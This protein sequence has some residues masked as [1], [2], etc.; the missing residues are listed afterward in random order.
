MRRKKR[1]GF[2]GKK[3][4]EISREQ[5]KSTEGT[6]ES[7]ASRHVEPEPTPT[8]SG[9]QQERRGNVPT[10]ANVSA[11]K[12]VN[13]SFEMLEEEEGHLTRTKSKKLGLSKDAEDS[14]AHGFKLQ[15]ATLLS[16]C[17][18]AATICSSC[19]KS[20]SKLQLFQRDKSRDGLS[21]YLYLQCSLCGNKTPLKTSR[22]LGG[23]GEGA[24]E[25]N[26]RSFLSSHQ[27]GLSGLT[28]VCAV[29][30]LP[31]PVTKKAYNEHLIQIEKHS[32]DN[33]EKPMCEA[34]ERL[35]NLT[36]TETPERVEVT[37]DG[38]IIADVAV[39]VDGT[40]QK[41]GLCYTRA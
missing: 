12:L 37:A 22:R 32:V 9:I 26:R 21:E 3:A 14:E 31:P 13:S 35:K 18:S 19:R 23:K 16:E 24:H 30:D 33:A 28:K 1:K 10:N 25:V 29:M 39:P 41:R 2:H 36:A 15:D 38:D 40:W 6:I 7:E 27:W 8:T 4:W 5:R 17:V 34:A 11:Q 20:D